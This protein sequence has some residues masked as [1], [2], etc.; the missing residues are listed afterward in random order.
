MTDIVVITTSYPR[1]KGDAEG[2]F[3]SA[4]VRRL[5]LQGRVT[6]LAPG[7]DRPSL[8][9]EQV[10]GLPGSDAFGFPGALE[11]LKQR[12]RHVLGAARFVASASDWL[13]RAPTL[14]RAVAHFLL[15]CGVPIATRGLR[16]RSTELEV[17]VH[18]SDA[19]LFTRL[20][21]VRGLLG[22]DLIRA[23]ARLRF[24]SSELQKL[25]LQSLPVEQRA[26][27]AIASRIEASPLDF[28]DVPAKVDAR[29]Q[30]QL[31]PGSK[32]AVIV[33]RLVPG[34]RAEIALEACRRVSSLTCYVIG[35]GPERGRLSAL[36]P[37]ARFVGH[38]A[39]PVALSYI[40]AADVLVSASLQEGAPSAIREARALGTP[41]V[42]LDAGDLRSWA[43]DDPGLCIARPR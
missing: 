33:A 7:R 42:C 20:P 16:G 5:C 35:D 23:G 39:R 3:V 32:L 26:Q 28:Q 17:V 22:R 8:W 11:K 34:K 12:R 31:D 1:R 9:G 43:A 36:F 30:L 14:D 21:A 2:H 40:A 38:V 19:R 10:V 4:E 15:P 25:V 6:V 13:R 18:G 24:V 41:V 37:H 29:R 27:L